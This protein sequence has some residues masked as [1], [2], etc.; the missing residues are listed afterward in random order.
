MPFFKNMLY[1]AEFTRISLPFRNSSPLFM[2][3]VIYSTMFILFIFYNFF[4]KVP[5]LYLPCRGDIKSIKSGPLFGTFKKKLFK[6]FLL[7]CN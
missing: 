7:F 5:F 4:P 2:F 1:F 3:L 6:F